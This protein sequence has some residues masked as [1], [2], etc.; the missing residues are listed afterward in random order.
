MAT[1]AL[2]F[3]MLFAH[4]MQQAA[5]LT[6]VQSSSTE[7]LS[8]A[9]TSWVKVAAT[10]GDQH[11]GPF[12]HG[13][14]CL[15]GS[16][17]TGSASS[18]LYM[19]TFQ[20]QG[21]PSQVMICLDDGT[22]TDIFQVAA[23]ATWET[24]AS[25]SHNSLSLALDSDHGAPSPWYLIMPRGGLGLCM[26][27]RLDRAS[28]MF[29]CDGDAG[30]GGNMLG[31]MDNWASED[32]ATGGGGRWRASFETESSGTPKSANTYANL[33]FSYAQTPTPAVAAV[34]DPHLQNVHGERFDLMRPG[35]HVLINIPKDLVENALLRV[36]A[37]ARRLGGQCAD[38][39]FQEI[40]ITG[41]WVEA[42]FAGGLRFQVSGVTGESAKWMTFG[43]VQVKVA[44]GHTLHGI[45]YLNF[46]VKHLGH[47]GFAV[48]G[49]LG[50]DDHTDVMIPPASC[51]HTASMRSAQRTGRTPATSQSVAMAI[52]E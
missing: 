24:P 3:A 36:E 14:S 41:P 6:Q 19:S 37:E 16:C 32:G 26:N 8:R 46:Y 12:G 43:K 29:T 51:T 15:W 48:G 49:L 20:G 22:C 45:H 42:Q 5:S 40:N 17:T 33:Y 47:A 50:E 23:G 52:S 25:N 31:L 9:Q 44:H 30:Q 4:R 28:S 2:Y 34:G 11:P 39:Y 13:S 1:R 18:G 7:V 21:V 35:R 27:Q 38:M 10:D